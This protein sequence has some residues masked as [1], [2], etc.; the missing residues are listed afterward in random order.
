[1]FCHVLIGIISCWKSLLQE[2][3]LSQR[4]AFITS[5][6]VDSCR[7]NAFRMIFFQKAPTRAL[8]DDDTCEFDSSF[9]FVTVR[10][11]TCE[12]VEVCL[13]G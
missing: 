9:K 8:W 5:V 10:K 6:H 7:H 4:W 12:N 3:V 11:Q 2:Q 13:G 1:M